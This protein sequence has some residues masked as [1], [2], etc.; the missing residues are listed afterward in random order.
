MPDH[1]GSHY[2]AVIGHLHAALKPQRYFE[3][4]VLHGVTLAIAQCEA[5]AVDPAYT[6]TSDVFGQK[7]ACHLY[8]ETSDAF[9]AKHSPLTVMGGPIDLAFLD[10]MHHY[11]FLLRDFINTERFCKR[12][13]VIVMHDCIPTDAYVARRDVNEAPDGTSSAH[14]E[15]WAGDVWKTLLILRNL[16]AGPQNL[17]SR[18]ASHRN[19]G[20]HQ[21]GPAVAGACRPL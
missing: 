8:R 14:K 18:R 15:W 10:G 9:F 19:R 13:S 2:L 11:E 4:G 12:N 3:I 21:P 1:A 5:L 7:P 6:I 20:R 16:S 17:L